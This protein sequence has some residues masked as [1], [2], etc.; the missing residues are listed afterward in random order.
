MKKISI[1]GSTGSIGTTTLRIVDEN[2]DLFKA[3]TLV[4]GNN[5]ERLIEQIKKFNPKHVYITAEENAQRIK[6]EFPN[7][8][9]YYG[10]K[11]L[12]E[13]S[14]LEDADIAVS[15]LVGISGLEPTYNMIKHTKQVALA[16]KEV[17]VT[18]GALIMNL[19]KKYNTEL[20]TVQQIHW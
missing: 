12:K 1:F 6:K 18:G 10:E 17:L 16:N 19:A 15:A 3:V 14:K 7:L 4:A 5:I 11:G 2:P 20:L 9:I 8:D 13:I